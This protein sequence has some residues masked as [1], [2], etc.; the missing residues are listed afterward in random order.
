MSIEMKRK[1]GLV[2]IVA[3][4][5]AFSFVKGLAAEQTKE[6]LT[7]P[8]GIEESVKEKDLKVIK[9]FVEEKTRNLTKKAYDCLSEGDVDQYRK[10]YEEI[11]SNLKT[12]VEKY[13]DNFYVSY[14]KEYIKTAQEEKDKWN[15]KS[16]NEIQN[17]F[18]D[19]NLKQLGLALHMYAQDYN[20]K[21]P[22]DL[23][24]LLVKRYIDTPR[25]FWCSADT[26]PRPTDITNSIPNTVNSS[27]ISYT[28]YL[29]PGY[30][31]DKVSA[32]GIPSNKIVIMEDNTTNYHNG[33]KHR[34]CLDGHVEFEKTKE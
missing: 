6:Q 26:D 27:Q 3:I 30:S 22:D 23:K 5:L 31:T 10:I 1:I 17:I 32:A 25:I 21:F 18:C 14:A 33:W 16:L 13:P 24:E 28:Y 29:Y 19:S 7:K 11:I 15:D 4:S 12:F 2:G 8:A 20:N 34:L 9:E